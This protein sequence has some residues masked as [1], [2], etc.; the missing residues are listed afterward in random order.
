MMHPGSHPDFYPVFVILLH[1]FEARFGAC[2][3]N[4]FQAQDFSF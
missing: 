2:F 4:D 1:R 3:L